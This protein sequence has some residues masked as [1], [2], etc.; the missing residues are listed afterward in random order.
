MVDDRE[1]WIVREIFKM[2]E[3]DM[4]YRTIAADLESRDILG[5]NRKPM[6][7]STVRNILE[8]KEFYYGVKKYAG[9]QAEGKHPAIL[10]VKKD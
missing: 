2:R 6:S 1:A 5:R 10:G 8:H 7:F 3:K 9:S 4:A